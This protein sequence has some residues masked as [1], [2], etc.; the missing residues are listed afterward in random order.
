MLY[1]VFLTIIVGWSSNCM[2]W[3]KE[4][5][6][7]FNYD[8]YYKAFSSEDTLLFNQELVALRPYMGTEKDAFYGAILMKKSKSLP[9]I[10]RKLDTFREG[11]E[12][13][14]TSIKK[15][16]DNIEFR[17]LRLATQE[18]A[19]GFLSYNDNKKEDAARI[20]N[21]FD[22]LSPVAQKYIREYARVSESLKTEDLK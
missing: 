22:Q 19:P 18:N 1:R 14:E 10:K 4:M 5:Q 2:A 12:L 8:S 16:P 15:D 11:R 17:F 20:V 21:S 7:A 6:A 9:T 3:Q 13:L